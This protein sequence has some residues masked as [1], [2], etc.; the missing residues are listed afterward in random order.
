M[1]EKR[2]DFKENDDDGDEDKWAATKNV[3]F[4]INLMQFISW[5]NFNV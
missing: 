5:E 4:M 2:G 1:T 3:E